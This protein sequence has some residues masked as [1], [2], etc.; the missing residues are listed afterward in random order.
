M[1]AFLPNMSLNFPYRG[2]KDVKV[3]KYLADTSVSRRVAV[4]GAGTYAVAIHDVLFNAFKSL[5]I[6]P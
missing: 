5:P 1:Q 3:I 4:I 2:W 6:M